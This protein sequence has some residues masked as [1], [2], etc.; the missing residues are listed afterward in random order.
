MLFPDVGWRVL[1]VVHGVS[2]SGSRSSVCVVH[3][4]S[5]EAFEVLVNPQPKSRLSL[6]AYSLNAPE[7]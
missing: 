4:Q 6:E 3:Q 2:V 1:Q 5:D 7:P